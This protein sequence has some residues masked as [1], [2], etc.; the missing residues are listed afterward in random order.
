MV[1]LVVANSKAVAEVLPEDK[2]ARRFKPKGWHLAAIRMYV[3]GMRVT[4]IAREMKKVPSTVHFAINRYPD[5]VE[6]AA[7]ELADPE[8]MFLPMMP[9][10]AAAYHRVLER[11]EAEGDV[12]DAAMSRVQTA[13]AQDVFDRAYGRPV[14]R[15]IN[16]GKHEIHITFHDGDGDASQKNE[17]AIL[18]QLEAS[19]A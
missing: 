6:A 19:N 2:M 9:K 7:R 17:D 16:E 8:K 11:G 1:E 4:D 10:A 5:L 15:N 13:V 18:A 3:R 12:L 14:Q